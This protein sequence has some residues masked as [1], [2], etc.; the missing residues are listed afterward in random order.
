M[1][2]YQPELYYFMRYRLGFTEAETYIDSQNAKTIFSEDPASM[3]TLINPANLQFFFEKYK[4]GDLHTISSRFSSNKTS[5]LTTK[6]VDAIY[7]YLV[8]ITDREF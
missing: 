3:Q 6:Q 8:F 2:G 7:K 1:A 4:Q 5:L